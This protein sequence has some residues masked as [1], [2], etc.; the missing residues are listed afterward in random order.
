DVVF[1]EGAISTAEQVAQ[2]QEL[3][4]QA[5]FLV[6]IGACATAGGIQALRNWADHDEFRAAV[7][8][9]PEYVESL[10][11]ATPIS[12]HVHVDAEL[13]GCPIDPGQLLELMTAVVVGRRPQIRDEA[14]CREC[15]RRGFVCV[16][17]AKGEACLGPVTQSGC[18]ALCPAYARGCYSCFGPRR[19]A[20]AAGWSR[21]LLSQ[22]RPP[23]EV[24]RIF[25]GFTSY[26]EPYRP[27]VTELGSQSERRA[28]ST[29]FRVEVPTS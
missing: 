8:E 9:H 7:Y 23:E 22:G 3:R 24:W 11:R 15:K 16:A 25:A 19:Q 21:A 29:H 26:A 6:T 1:A 28:G 14:V 13:R 4:R 18:G 17:V 10:E 5:R 27:V 12:E 2:I 20:N